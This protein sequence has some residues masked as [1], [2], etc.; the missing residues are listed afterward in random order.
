[1]SHS[2]SF[3]LFSGQKYIHFVTTLAGSIFR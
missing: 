1:M 3:R 2:S